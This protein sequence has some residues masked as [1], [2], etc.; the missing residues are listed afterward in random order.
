MKKTMKVPIL[1]CLK[2]GHEWMART[3]NPPK[4]CPKCKRSDWQKQRLDKK[5]PLSS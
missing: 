5:Y 1:N 4:V 3:V 2:C